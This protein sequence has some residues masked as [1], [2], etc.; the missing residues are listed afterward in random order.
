MVYTVAENVH[1]GL[2]KI[3]EIFAINQNIIPLDIKGEYLFSLPAGQPFG[4]FGIRFKQ[5]FEG[6]I[7]YFLKAMQKF[8]ILRS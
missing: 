6:F 8:I 1:Q 2:G 7:S 3:P 4:I 5:F